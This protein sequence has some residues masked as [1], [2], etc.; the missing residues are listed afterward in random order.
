MTYWAYNGMQH[1]IGECLPP[2]ADNDNLELM[3]G[4]VLTPAE[5]MQW[6]RRERR[7]LSRAVAIDARLWSCPD[8]R[9][10]WIVTLGIEKLTL[11]K[12]YGIWTA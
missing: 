1:G 6:T 7:R 2:P 5:L 4:C 8:H 9:R 10:D 3:R 11:W 12:C